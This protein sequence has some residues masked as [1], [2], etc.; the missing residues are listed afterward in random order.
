MGNSFKLQILIFTIPLCICCIRGLC[1]TY[2]DKQSMS[3]A[4][5]SISIFMQ[6]NLVLNQ[7]NSLKHWTIDY[8][9]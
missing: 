4:S 6:Q 3:D 7:Q 8:I 9:M 1:R 5:S 2:I